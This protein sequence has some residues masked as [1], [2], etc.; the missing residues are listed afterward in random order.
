MDLWN[1]NSKNPKG[2]SG[3]GSVEP[4]TAQTGR[5]PTPRVVA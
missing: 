5:G 4:A 3:V 2:A 1:E